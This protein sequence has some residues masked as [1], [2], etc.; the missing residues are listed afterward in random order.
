MS[1]QLISE[2]ITIYKELLENIKSE[3]ISFEGTKLMYGQD[4]TNTKIEQFAAIIPTLQEDV[5]NNSIQEC[6]LLSFKIALQLHHDRLK[7]WHNFISQLDGHNYDDK[8]IVRCI[9]ILEN[10][11]CLLNKVVNPRYQL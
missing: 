7:R 11:I 6:N 3:V 9:H 4:F 5:Q 8:E 1:Y 2:N 10:D